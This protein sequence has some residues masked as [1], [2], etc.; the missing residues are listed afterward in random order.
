MTESRGIETLTV[1]SK[2]ALS[3]V[4]TGSDL[5]IGKGGNAPLN[6]PLNALNAP[7]NMMVMIMIP[8]AYA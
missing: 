4:E 1:K 7:P 6:A 8:L 2:V 3:R 5:G